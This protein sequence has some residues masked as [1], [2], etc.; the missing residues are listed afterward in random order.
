MAL[1]KRS[2]TSFFSVCVWYITM[3]FAGHELLLILVS[4]ALKGAWVYV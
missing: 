3:N 4:S 1:D 2:N